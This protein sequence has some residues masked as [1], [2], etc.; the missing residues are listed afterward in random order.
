MA[1][2]PSDAVVH[3]A[4]LPVAIWNDQPYD[5]VAIFTGSATVVNGKPGESW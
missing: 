2:I 1:L 3:W 5:R 4:R